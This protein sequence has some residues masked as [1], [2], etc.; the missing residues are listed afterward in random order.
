[1]KQVQEDLLNEHLGEAEINAE[2][3]HRFLN[4]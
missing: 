1:M 2:A 4:A 3:V